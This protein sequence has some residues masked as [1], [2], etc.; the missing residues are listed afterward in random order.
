MLTA[1]VSQRHLGSGA[2]T[3]KFSEAALADHAGTDVEGAS[4]GL[5][6]TRGQPRERADDRLHR[7]I[8]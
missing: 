2:D 7:K 4:G 8:T 6:L 3:C 1:G 5:G